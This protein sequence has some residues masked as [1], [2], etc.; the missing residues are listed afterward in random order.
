MRL[1]DDLYVLA[2]VEEAGLLDRGALLDCLAAVQTTRQADGGPPVR[3]ALLARHPDLAERLGR[4]GRGTAVPG[5]EALVTAC[6]YASRF[7]L[8]THK[9]L[10]VA[11]ASMLPAT[12]VLHEALEELRITQEVVRRGFADPEKVAECRLEHARRRRQGEAVDLA[13]LLLERGAVSGEQFAELA[14]SADKLASPEDVARPRPTGAVPGLPWLVASGLTAAAVLVVLGIQVLSSPPATGPQ[15]GGPGTPPGGVEGAS[16][17]AEWI[18]SV[19]RPPEGPATGEVRARPLGGSLYEAMV[20][21]AARWMEEAPPP[22]QESAA[23][24]AVRVA[25]VVLREGALRRPAASGGRGAEGAPPFRLVGE[26]SV[27]DGTRV[28]SALVFQGQVVSWATTLT[29]D[30]AFEVGFG[31]FGGRR[32]QHGAYTV[33]VRVHQP[34][35]P[36]ETR[37]RQRPLETRLDF[38]EGTEAEASADRQAEAAFIR[39]RLQCVGYL[40]G[41]LEDEFA[42]AR[43]GMGRELTWPM[44]LEGWRGELERLGPASIRD[45]RERE[46]L[47]PCFPEVLTRVDGI[48]ERL[49]RLA[50]S[51]ARVVEAA[52][53]RPAVAGAEDPEAASLLAELGRAREWVEKRVGGG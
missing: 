4:L 49:S 43:S 39:A 33:H 52:R 7:A 40:Q 27:P 32:V 16:S 41:G 30:Q 26:A 6:A 19:G 28:D 10:R 23:G 11:L 8:A 45:Y 24:E 5:T 36:R 20:S 9:E 42:R 12:N 3:D 17:T 21:T 34:R 48:F 15:L 35:D 31:P 18:E 47:A 53:G 38:R 37:R 44:W 25:Q 13:A 51:R 29:R 14:F 22:P 46:V 50:D 1:A 2:R